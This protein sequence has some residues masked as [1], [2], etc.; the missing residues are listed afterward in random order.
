MNYLSLLIY[1]NP[2]GLSAVLYFNKNNIK[3]KF[4]KLQTIKNI[5]IEV[6]NGHEQKGIGIFGI[7]IILAVFRSPLH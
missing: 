7:N 3:I 5:Y 1:R 2:R 6:K 4:N